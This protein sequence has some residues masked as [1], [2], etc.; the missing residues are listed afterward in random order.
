[1]SNLSHPEEDTINKF[2]TAA[3]EINVEIVTKLL[4][5]FDWRT[6]ITGAYFAAIN[7]YRELEDII[8]R[9]L[10]KSEVCYAGLGYCLALAASGSDNSKKYLRTYLEYYLDRIDLW[11]D[12]AH[13]FCALEYLDK[14]QA[15][16]Y[17]TK[18]TFFVAD[19]KYWNLEKSRTHFS[20][21]MLTLEKIRQTMN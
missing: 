19:K 1:M 18:W 13:A 3:K 2:A 5:D 6:R 10:L 14:N 17:L 16:E 7:N 21:C 4:S 12:Q 15:N 20:E 11:F 8:G 9:H